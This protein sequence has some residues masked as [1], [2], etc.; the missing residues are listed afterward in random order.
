MKTTMMLGVALL[1]VTGACASSSHGEK[2]RDARME[3]ADDRATGQ[4][5][6]G[7]T[8]DLHQLSNDRTDYQAHAREEL[9]KQRVRIDTSKQKLAIL[10]AHA[11]ASLASD[12]AT[13]EKQ[14]SMI[15][16]E[17]ARLD[18]TSADRWD[19]AKQRVDRDL[20]DLDE[21]LSQVASKIDDQH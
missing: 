7:A 9:G 21:R 18:S 2:V 10:G 11:P 8:E 12:L 3:Q 17:V 4:P 19:S 1:S 14:H 15:S 16:D 6:T 5:A 13:A 20:S